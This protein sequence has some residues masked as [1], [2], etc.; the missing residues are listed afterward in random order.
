MAK[1]NNVG[2]HK[3]R[4]NEEVISGL[5]ERIKELN[6]LYGLCE[7]VK[8]HDIQLE[9]IFHGLVDLIPSAWHCPEITCAK[10]V[11][12]DGEFKTDNFRISK[13]KQSAEII[14][15]GNKAGTIEV[16]Y[17]EEKTEIDEGPFLKTERNL[18]NALAERVGRIAERKKAEEA[19]KKFKQELRE[20]KLALEQKNLALKELIEHMERAKNKAK[21]DIA[22]NVEEITM[23]ILKKL[24]LKGLSPKYVDLLC[25]HLNELTS[26]FGRMIT[27]RSPKLSSREIEISNLIKGGLRSKEISELLNVS[28]QTIDKHR[29][30]IR[31]KL[32]ISKKRANL[33][34]FLQKL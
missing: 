5:N 7:L 14:M 11:F 31:K 20:D 9:K 27:Q 26:S 1:D 24:R 28:Y 10:I 23:P 25:H 33:T 15:Y 19:L 30:N 4:K 16:G 17:L 34:S 21:E 6:C 2:N 18:L 22:I 12:E 3:K 13:W 32:G 8:K 29:R